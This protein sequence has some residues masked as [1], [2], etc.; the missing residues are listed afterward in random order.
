MCRKLTD[1]FKEEVVELFTDPGDKLS[2][3]DRNSGAHATQLGW[4]VEGK[5]LD[6]SHFRVSM[7]QLQAKL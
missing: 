2:G 6:S 7:A 1:E 5:A 4:R 3:A